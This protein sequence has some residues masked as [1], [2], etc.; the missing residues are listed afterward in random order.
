MQRIFNERGQLFFREPLQSTLT[1][2]HGA[3]VFPMMSKVVSKVQTII[4]Y[5]TLLE[6][7]LLFETVH[8]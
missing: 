8:K 4:F 1:N 7:E 6:G 2:I 5:S 3:C